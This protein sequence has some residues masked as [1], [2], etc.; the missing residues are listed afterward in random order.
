MRR[1]KL[2]KEESPRDAACTGLPVPHVKNSVGKKEKKERLF[3]QLQDGAWCDE[4]H[5]LQ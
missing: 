1:V 2:R 3:N 4:L 5:A